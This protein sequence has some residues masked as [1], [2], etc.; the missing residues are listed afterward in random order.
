MTTTTAECRHTWHT[1]QPCT[2]SCA[3]TAWHQC[4]SGCGSAAVHFCFCGA[5][6]P[7]EAPQRPVRTEAQWT[8]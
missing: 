2:A 7:G 5:T 8:R 1:D 6:E 4:T 3:I